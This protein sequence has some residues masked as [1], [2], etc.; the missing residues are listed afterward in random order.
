ME[1]RVVQILV[2]V[3]M[4]QLE[5]LKTDVEQGSMGRAFRHGSI[6]PKCWVYS[7]V[8]WVLYFSLYC[9]TPRKGRRLKFLRHAAQCSLLCLATRGNLGTP[10]LGLGRDV[11]SFSHLVV[12][13]LTAGTAVLTHWKQL[14]WRRC[15]RDG[16]AC[17][18]FANWRVENPG[19]GP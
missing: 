17:S 18:L 9:A 8:N 6:G 5:T 11:S 1:E 2:G 19:D 12:S 16:K 15:W 13:A 10:A 3:A 7:D 14:G 4:I